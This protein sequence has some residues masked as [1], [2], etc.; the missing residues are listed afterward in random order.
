MT[1]ETQF[2]EEVRAKLAEI[3]DE[4]ES[5]KA[6]RDAANAE[7]DRLN[8]EHFRYLQIRAAIWSTAEA[9]M[10][11]SW[12]ATTV[13]MIPQECEPIPPADTERKRRD[14]R[15]EVL[16]FVVQCGPGVLPTAQGIANGIDA[17]QASVERALDW[18]ESHGRLAESPTGSWSV[19]EPPSAD[20]PPLGAGTEAAAATVPA[21]SLPPV[22]VDAILS[23]S[24]EVVDAEVPPRTIP[25]ADRVLDFVTRA[26]EIGVSE[27]QL[28]RIGATPSIMNIL[29]H[30]ETAAL[31]EDGRWRALPAADEGDT[32]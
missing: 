28:S 1:D 22:L 10:R 30:N 3:D 29:S 15:G 31:G 26:G 25:S 23:I 24:Q 20:T 2:P 14:I 7:V 5:N 18:H 16:A 8:I 19:S 27:E 12:S 17:P 21:S 11:A 13:R 4:L 6:H 9:C 32:A